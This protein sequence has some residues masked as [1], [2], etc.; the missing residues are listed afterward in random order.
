[1]GE[2]RQGQGGGDREGEG[3][4]GYFGGGAPSLCTVGSKEVG[5][6]SLSPQ[7]SQQLAQR[8]IRTECPGNARRMKARSYP[9]QTHGILW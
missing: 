5:T 1:M 3:V 6:G 4:H 7:C 9:A 2:R 8:L